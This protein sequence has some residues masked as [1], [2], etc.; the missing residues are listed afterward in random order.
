MSLIFNV[1]FI[2][3]SSMTG[4]IERPDSIDFSIK[5]KEIKGVSV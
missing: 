3:G 2:R 1:R 5:S 4:V